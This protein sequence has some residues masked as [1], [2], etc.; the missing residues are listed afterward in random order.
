VI[1]SG[2]NAVHRARQKHARFGVASGLALTLTGL[3]FACSIWALPI[4]A[5]L[6]GEAAGLR[7]LDAWVPASDRTGVDVPLLMTI[8]NETTSADQMLRISCPV[9][10]F[11]E[12]QT[13]DRGEGAPA[14]RSIK[15]IP[16]PAAGAITFKTSSHHVMLLQTRQILTEGDSF[17]CSIV[18]Q[19]AGSLE[20]EVH[21][22]HPG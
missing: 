3:T 2:L 9:A 20:T 8:Q 4:E 7:I 18:F 15:S 16:I 1:T 13:V 19:N 5:A 11:A 14:M 6:G 12:K 10:N 22:G 21:I 17:R